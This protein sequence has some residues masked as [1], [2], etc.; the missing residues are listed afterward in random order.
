MKHTIII[1]FHT[2]AKENADLII[3]LIDYGY[4]VSI[5]GIERVPSKTESTIIQYWREE[6]ADE[7]WP[8]SLQSRGEQ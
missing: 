5:H 7:K 2:S 6:L 4:A 1:P 8:E 3:R